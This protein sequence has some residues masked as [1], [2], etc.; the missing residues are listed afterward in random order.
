[1][2]G[3]VWYTVQNRCTVTTDSV[4]ANSKRQNAFLFPVHAMFRHDCPLAVKPASTPRLLVHTHTHTHT[5][6]GEILYLFICSFLLCLSWLLRSWVR[7][8]QRDLWITL[9]SAQVGGI[10]FKSVMHFSLM[11]RICK[12]HSQPLIWWMATPLSCLQL[13]IETC[14][15][16]PTLHIRVHLLLSLTMGYCFFCLQNVTHE[17]FMKQ[18]FCP[19]FLW[20]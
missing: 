2:G 20:M 9:Y 3:S 11:I 7:K 5:Q 10:P 17:E 15:F 1:M 16:L 4:L 6:L 19:R 18:S 8:S 14:T 13:L 12:H